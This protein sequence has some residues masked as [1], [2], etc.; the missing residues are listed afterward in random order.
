MRVVLS[1]APGAAPRIAAAATG[2]PVAPAIL[3][4]VLGTLLEQHF[5]T[6]MI[7]ADGNVLAFFDRPIAGTLGVAFIALLLGTALLPL[8]RARGQAKATG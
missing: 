6:S 2:F 5:V 4:M 7:K 8:L 1:S 3:G